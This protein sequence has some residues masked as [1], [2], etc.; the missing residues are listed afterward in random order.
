MHINFPFDRIDRLNRRK[1]ILELSRSSTDRS[2]KKKSSK[3]G[4]IMII[5]CKLVVLLVALSQVAAFTG[6]N[7]LSSSSRRSSGSTSSSSSSSSRRSQG[8]NVL[9]MVHEKIVV[10]GLGVIS[11]VGKTHE[12]FFNNI[13]NGVS[14]I[15][16]IDR[17]DPT[18]FKCQIGGQVKDFNPRDYY[19][20]KKK[21]KQNDL[22]THYA[23]AAA[24]TAMKDAGIDLGVAKGS[25]PTPGVDATRVG[26]VLGSAFGGMGS[27][28]NAANDLTAYGPGS[29]DPY[30]IPMIL[31]N[32]HAGIVGMEIG[33]KG[34][35]FAVQTAC[36]TATH[37]FGEALRLM[38][39]GDAD[40]M[41]AG[42]CEAALTPLSFAGFI[43]LMAMNNNYNDNPTKASRPFDAN[44][45]GFVMS[46]GAG[47]LVLETETHAKKRGAK[48]YCELAGYGA[49]CDAYHITSPAPEGEGLQRAMLDCLK[50]AGMKPEEVEYVNAHGTSTKKNDM[51]ET[52]AYKGAFGDHAK[53]L[54]I[55]SIKGQTGH[56][57]GAAGGFEAVACVKS[58]E[59][60]VLAPTI[61]FEE[62]DPDC[63]LDYCFNKKVEVPGLKTAM[64]DNLGFGGHNGVVVFRK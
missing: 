57:L 21:I 25:E 54:K 56:S 20:S 9:A 11:P 14:G 16:K 6:V 24:A 40:V 53:K 2:Q 43:N 60:G 55:S 5:Q 32:V 63:D 3:Q 41:I 34:P 52:M 62:A 13:C 8:G 27:F 59:H 37:A 38:R 39:N 47:V 58:L 1:D 28:E 31:G 26:C 23:V 4:I 35:N 30:T 48:I 15:A 50:D 49:S 19:N 42:G 33:C 7:R 12:E 64:S 45:G 61:N 46:E 29:I 18:P 17:F 22:A 44:R 10:T 36:A 51:F